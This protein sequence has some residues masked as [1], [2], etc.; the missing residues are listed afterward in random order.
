M[1]LE[2]IDADRDDL[3]LVQNDAAMLL[4]P[5]DFQAFIECEIDQ[6]AMLFRI[7]HKGLLVQTGHTYLEAP[8]QRH[9][10]HSAGF[11]ENVISSSDTWKSSAL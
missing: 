1:R 6:L 2:S 11:V 10:K 8:F 9:R 5:W 3:V 4:S 7:N